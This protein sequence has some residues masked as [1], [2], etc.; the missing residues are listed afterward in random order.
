MQFWS[1]SP[2]ALDS[3]Q[4]HPVKTSPSDA[5]PHDLPLLTREEVE[6]NEDGLWVIIGDVVYDG[7]SSH[8][9]A[10]NALVAIR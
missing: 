2:L 5:H 10:S 4:H 8:S 6:K 7:S 3:A 1:S 9:S